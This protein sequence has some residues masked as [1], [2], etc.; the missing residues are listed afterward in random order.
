MLKEGSHICRLPQRGWCQTLKQGIDTLKY[1]RSLCNCSEFI[2]S[3]S[4]RPCQQGS[5]RG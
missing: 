3:E 5:P 4:N 1:S 2:I